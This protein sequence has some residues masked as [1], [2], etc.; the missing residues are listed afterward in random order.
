MNRTISHIRRRPHLFAAGAAVLLLL[1]SFSCKPPIDELQTG[2]TD[3]ITEP[4][5]INQQQLLDDTFRIDISNIS[6]IYDW[7]PSDYSSEARAVVTFRMRPGQQRA[8][9][10]FEPAF[11]GTVPSLLRLNGEDLDFNHTG[12]VRVLEPEGSTQ[13]MLEFQRDLAP[14]V[15]HI[16]EMEYLYFVSVPNFP[17]FSTDVNDIYG[18]GNE[19]MFPTINTPHELARHQILFRIHAVEPYHC[20]GSGLVESL[21]V[22]ASGVREWRLD[23][24]REVASYS[25]MFVLL[26]SYDVI[27]QERTIAGVSVRIMAFRG[28]ASVDE[29]YSRLQQYLPRLISH[30]GPFPMPRGMSIFLAE[31]G[32]GMEY[33]GGTITSMNALEHEVFHMYFGCSTVA[34]TYRDSWFDEALDEWY[35]HSAELYH[36]PHLG[37]GYRTNIVSGRSPVAVGFDDRAYYEGAAVMDMVAKQ[38]GSQFQM[39]GFL[40]WLHQNYSFAPFTTFQ[41]LDYL[42]AYSGIRMHDQFENWLYDGQ[43]SYYGA[44]GGEARALSKEI[45]WTPPPEVLRRHAAPQ[46]D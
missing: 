44:G 46:T 22:N 5:Q 25:V 24:E 9:I 32:G 43:R 35:E 18:R 42:E 8:V 11:N 6:V 10:H 45:D 20:V 31:N 17:R 40:R 1:I 33:Y 19:T 34:A 3:T 7:N 4:Q 14:G 29:A 21:G 23:T 36:F 39:L 26:P 30:F 37:E 27:R 2:E 41:F 28:G 16:L 15:A 12:D 38:L 13:K